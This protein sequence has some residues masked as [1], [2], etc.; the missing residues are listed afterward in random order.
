[1]S[2][3]IQFN[4]GQKDCTGDVANRWF[5]LLRSQTKKVKTLID[6]TYFGNGVVLSKDESFVLMTETT[7]YR[8]LRYWLKGEKAGQTEVFADNLPGFPNGISITR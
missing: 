7:K 1:M 3:P 6:G 8:V 2:L 4:Y 5:L